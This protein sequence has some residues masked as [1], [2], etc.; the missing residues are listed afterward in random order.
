MYKGLG[1]RAQD[2][3]FR[4][5]GQGHLVKWLLNNGITRGYYVAHRSYMYTVYSLSPHDQ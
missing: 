5:W 2:F 1:F 3:G 4:V